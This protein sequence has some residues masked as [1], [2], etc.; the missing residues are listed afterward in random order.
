MKTASD[1]INR[2]GLKRS[3]LS[4]EIKREVRQ[5]CSFG[6]VVCGS[7]IVQYHHFD[8]PFA[9]A[10]QHRAD[11]ITLLC[12]GC[13]DKVTRRVWSDNKVRAANANPKAKQS[14]AHELLDL[15][16]PVYLVFGTMIF[17]GT[18]PLICIGDECLLELR[19][20]P[21]G[22][23]L[24]AQFFDEDNRPT[25][26]VTDNELQFCADAWDIEAVGPTLVVRRGPN[27]IVFK[28]QLWPPHG[29][30]VRSF[31]VDAHGWRVATDSKGRINVAH[32]SGSGLR[33][34]ADTASIHGGAL[35]LHRDGKFEQSDGFGGIP[36]PATR[37]RKWAGEGNIERLL[38]ELRFQPAIHVAALRDPLRPPPAD[39]VNGRPIGND[40]VRYGLYCEVCNEDRAGRRDLPEGKLPPERSGI[41]CQRCAERAPDAWGVTMAGRKVLARFAKRGEAIA[42][43]HSTLKQN[44]SWRLVIHGEHNESPTIFFGTEKLI[45]VQFDPQDVLSR[46][47]SDGDVY[48]GP[49]DG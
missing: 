45:P 15:S 41:I 48:L 49:G 12:G 34:G 26:V 9:D 1:S 24:N 23:R 17:I 11:G 38:W 8:P 13:H 39:A 35:R 25:V 44:S 3:E 7:V 18:G 46:E 21:E 16:A 31:N 27:N 28:A 4:A 33:F 2:F 6:C 37:F 40:L 29:V 22:T 42:Y 5:R 20:T 36:Y 47:G 30:Y 19:F 43:G 10:T 32:K 14:S